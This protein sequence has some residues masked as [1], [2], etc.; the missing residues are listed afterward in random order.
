M[1]PH[2][3][4]LVADNHYFY[5][6]GLR[7]LFERTSDFELVAEV[8]TATDAVNFARQHKPDIVLIDLDI[9]PANGIKATK[10]IK[11]ENPDCY[12]LVL[13]NSENE[14]SIYD[15]LEAGATGYL[16]K[17]TGHQELRRTIRLVASGSAVFASKVTSYLHKF[18]NKY[19]SAL[20]VYHFPELTVRENEV[21]GFVAKGMKNKEVAIE[22]DITEKT[23]RNHMTSILSKLGAESRSEAVSRLQASSYYS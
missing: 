2:I 6:D 14:N 12:I 1:N 20:P 13:T 16:L 22:C 11:E 18:F 23:V 15:A 17:G 21:L 5:R 3:R 10:Q 4:I 8:D 9:A 7:L 19:S